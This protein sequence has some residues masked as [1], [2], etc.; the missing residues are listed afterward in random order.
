MQVLTDVVTVRAEVQVD[1]HWNRQVFPQN[2][3]CSKAMILEHDA[4]IR[5]NVCY[6]VHED[7]VSNTERPL[8][9]RTSS[10]VFKR[11]KWSCVTSIS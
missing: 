6:L 1:G 10:T 2:P 9:R 7:L 4:V 8:A 11:V 5:D 3:P